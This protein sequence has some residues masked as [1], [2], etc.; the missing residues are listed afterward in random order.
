MGKQNNRCAGLQAL[1]I[2]LEPV[3]LFL[4][5]NAQS[6][7]LNIGHVDQADE[8]HAFLVET[9]PSAAVCILSKS[10]SEEG[11]VVVDVMLA[12]NIEDFG[13]F[14]VLQQLSQRIKF[15]RI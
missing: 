1:H 12:G 14:A 11:A 5:E 15:G 9:V 10:L 7:F 13:G 3:Q 4:T 2:F 6:P 8:M